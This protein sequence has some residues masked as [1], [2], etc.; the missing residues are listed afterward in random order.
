M[1]YLH[2]VSKIQLH[3]LTRQRAVWTKASILFLSNNTRT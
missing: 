2:I 3:V 1:A